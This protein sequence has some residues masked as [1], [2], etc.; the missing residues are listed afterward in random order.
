MHLR[1]QFDFRN[2]ADS[3]NFVGETIKFKENKYVINAAVFF[4][5]AS[6]LT[7]GY[8]CMCYHGKVNASV[9]VVPY[10]IM[11]HVVSVHTLIIFVCRS[12]MQFNHHF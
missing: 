4:S 8:W 12:L 9:S 5:S 11:L 1:A 10:K 3:N 7:G 2:L 6:T